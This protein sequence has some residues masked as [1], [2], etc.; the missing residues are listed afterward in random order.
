L[1]ELYEKR[2]DSTE[3]GKKWDWFLECCVDIILV[4]VCANHLF[5]GLW[6]IIQA[7]HSKIDFDF[8]KYSKERL[9]HGL[10]FSLGTLPHDVKKIIEYEKA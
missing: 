3:N 8:K 4:F 5:W 7:K 2:S 10:Q 6:A 9:V 1:K